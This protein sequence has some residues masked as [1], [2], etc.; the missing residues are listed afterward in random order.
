M[1][2]KWK[3]GWGETKFTKRKNDGLAIEGRRTMHKSKINTVYNSMLHS[4]TT[5]INDEKVAVRDPYTVTHTARR[6][7]SQGSNLGN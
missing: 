4:Y 2:K 7:N 6:R 1:S 5:F 3:L